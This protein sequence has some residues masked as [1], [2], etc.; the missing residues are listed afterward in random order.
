LK[1]L[2]P[3]YFRRNAQRLLYV[4]RTLRPGVE[5]AVTTIDD[6][7]ARIAEWD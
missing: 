3:K 4:S 6:N 2:L 7:A 5:S 1:E